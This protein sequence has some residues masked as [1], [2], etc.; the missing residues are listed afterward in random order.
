R[1]TQVHVA[2]TGARAAPAQFAEAEGADQ[3]DRPTHDPGRERQL[4]RPYSLRDG[5][6]R[7]EDPAADDAADHGHRAG[8]ETEAPRVGRHGAGKWHE[9]CSWNSTRRRGD[10]TRPAPSL[11]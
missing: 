5:R 9:R 3:G 1:F 2:A 4:G 10:A 6:G 11:P 7:A 8:E